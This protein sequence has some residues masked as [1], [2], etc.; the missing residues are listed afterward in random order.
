M[1]TVPALL[2]LVALSLGVTVVLYAS[3]RRDG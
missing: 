1:P 3:D 2:W